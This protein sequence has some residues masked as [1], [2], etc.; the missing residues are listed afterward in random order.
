MACSSTGPDQMR[1]VYATISDSQFW[2][3]KGSQDLYPVRKNSSVRPQ[4]MIFD[5]LM[6]HAVGVVMYSSVSRAV[7]LFWSVLELRPHGGSLIPP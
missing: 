5:V 7:L 1:Q 4:S 2:D 6:N 3:L